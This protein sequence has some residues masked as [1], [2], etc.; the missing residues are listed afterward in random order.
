MLEIRAIP[1]K[2]YHDI[3]FWILYQYLIHTDVQV[4]IKNRR[5]VEFQ[6]QL[7]KFTDNDLKIAGKEWSFNWN[8]LYNDDAIFYKVL[9]EKRIQGIIKLEE[10][11]EAY[12]VLKNI[13]IEPWNFGS[14]GK[15][16]NI[17]EI[18]MSFACLKSL[19][20]N[21]G[22][23]RGFLVFTSKGALIE[24][25]QDKYGAE[26]IFRDRMITSPIIGRKLI[27]SNLK[28]DIANEEYLF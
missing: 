23:Y 1:N 13:E 8:Q 28:I 18:L 4:Q 20:L 26:L 21:T 25:Y 12:H 27:L 16:K 24:Y 3:F 17:A 19:E 9:Y 6:A 7:D 5:N 10:E 11:N 2:S 15:Y 22:N 14:T